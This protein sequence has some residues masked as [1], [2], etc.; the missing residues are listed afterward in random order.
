[1]AAD[2]RQFDEHGFPIPP[3]FSDLKYHDEDQP[4]ARPKASL[5]TKR[6]VMLAI[7]LGVIVP[8]VLGPRILATGR[9]FVA[10][11]LFSRAQQRFF[12]G[13][14]V[15]ALADLNRAIDWN[16]N[17]WMLY[18]L[19][20]KVRSK[21]DQLDDSLADYTELVNLL[22]GNKPGLRRQRGV[23]RSGLLAEA[24]IGRS[25]VNVRLKRNREALDDASGAVQ[26]APN[27]TTWNSRAYV[28]AILNMELDDGLA[29]INRALA[30]DPGNAEFLDTRGYLLHRLGRDKEG[31]EDMNRAL[32]EWN[33]FDRAE[34]DQA[35]RLELDHSLGVMFHHR[36]EIYQT[37]GEK[38]KAEVDIRRGENLGYDPAHGVF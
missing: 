13:D 3:R 26:F 10:Q 7:L 38:D 37:L 21:M 16:P 29:D 1:M 23:H 31:L 20:A 27:A 24:L 17:S 18:L 12:Q 32:A 9:D 30:L 33:Q 35:A 14:N 22:N 34:M 4:A 8:I 2:F 36:G 28:R 15:G 6:L 25:W 11:W 5:R 19:R